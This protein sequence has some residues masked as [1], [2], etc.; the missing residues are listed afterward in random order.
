MQVHDIRHEEDEN[1]VN[2]SYI[3]QEIEI[4]LFIY[5]RE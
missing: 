2:F 1:R 4:V 5:T 3:D